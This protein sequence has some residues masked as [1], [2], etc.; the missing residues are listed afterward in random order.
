[1][2]PFLAAALVL[3]LALV[4]L[5]GAQGA[6][7]A[8]PGAVPYPI[9]GGVAAPLVVFLACFV[10]SA[11]FRS[12]L[13]ALDLP[14][15]TVVQ[16]WRF[17]G[18]GFLALA[19]HGVLPGVFAWPAG[20]GDMAIG[21]TAPWMARALSRRPGFAAGRWFV[22]WNLLG[23]LDLVVAVSIAGLDSTFA[24]GAPGEITVTPMAQ[25][26]LVLVPAFL[27]PLFLMLHLTALF[28]ARRLARSAQPKS[29]PADWPRQF[30]E[31]LNA[32]DLDA[33]LELYDPD[34]RF[35]A[36]TGETLVGRDRI[37]DVLAGM[38]RA[39]THLQSHVIQTVT[40]GDSALLYSDFEG[41]T[42]DASNATVAAR[43]QAIEVL[44]RRPD[45]TWKLIVGDPAGRDE[46]RAVDSA[47][48]HAQ[49]GGRR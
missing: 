2:K 9:L 19:A 30:T 42:V 45:G 21:L 3:W 43:H 28:Q 23:I 25:M 32:G 1:M 15:V 49:A 26:P 40:V 18:F 34:A 31:H 38:I 35:V 47:P 10:M 37:R 36:R 48:G 17:A 24:T 27:V 11:A 39:H 41:T 8:P 46:V 29:D 4:L 22:V 33:V 20:L 6:F 7:V 5:L 16:A 44:R 13:L 14:M 12:F